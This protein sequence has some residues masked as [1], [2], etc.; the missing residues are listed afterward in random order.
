MPHGHPRATR[1][2]YTVVG[3]YSRKKAETP[4]RPLRSGCFLKWANF[5]NKPV[6]PSKSMFEKTIAFSSICTVALVHRRGGHRAPG[7]EG[8]KRG[9]GDGLAPGA[10]AQWLRRLAPQR[11]R[12]S[13]VP[14]TLRLRPRPTRGPTHSSRALVRHTEYCMKELGCEERRRGKHGLRRN[15]HCPISKG[16]RRPWLLDLVPIKTFLSLFDRSPLV[17]VLDFFWSSSPL[18]TFVV[19]TTTSPHNLRSRP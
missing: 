17:F 14:I 6:K 12:V 13:M 18:F 15:H 10:L 3:T 19:L 7:A 2:Y 5:I 11:A 1:G 9:G 8:R 4:T 16:F